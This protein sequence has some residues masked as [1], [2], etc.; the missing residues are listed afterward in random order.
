[1]KI[2]AE[3]IVFLVKEE[4]VAVAGG[5]VSPTPC[6]VLSVEKR[7]Q[8]ILEN[9]DEMD[10]QEERSILKRNLPKMRIIQSSGC[11]LCTTT[12]GGWTSS[13]L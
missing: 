10:T 5:K 13:T 11:T 3:L 4:R 9:L 2:V 8:H 6:S 1:M 7:W 12:R